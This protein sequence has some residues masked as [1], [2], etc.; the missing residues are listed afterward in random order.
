MG[1]GEWTAGRMVMKEG[2]GAVAQEEVR[3]DEEASAGEGVAG[4][5]RAGANAGAVSSR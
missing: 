3:V 2:M 4:R 5:A 1:V